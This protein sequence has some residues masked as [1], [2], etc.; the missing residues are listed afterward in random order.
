MKAQRRGVYYDQFKPAL[1][2]GALARLLIVILLTFLDLPKGKAQNQ[3]RQTRQQKDLHLLRLVKQFGPALRC[4]HAYLRCTLRC[5]SYSIAHV[6]ER[7]L[8]RP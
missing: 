1:F 5:T 7:R 4:S 2:Y 3:W 6:H 8:A